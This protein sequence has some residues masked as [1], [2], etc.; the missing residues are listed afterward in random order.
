MAVG[1]DRRVGTKRDRYAKAQRSAKHRA[2]RGSG[3]ARLFGN[4]GWIVVGV[5]LDPIERHEGGDKETAL[6]LHAFQRLFGQEAAVLDRIDAGVDGE[7][8]GGIAVR[9]GCGLAGTI[10]SLSD[11]GVEL[12]ER[13]ERK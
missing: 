11:R 2:M 8:R 9:M 3:D 6:F 4:I 10:M 7:P 5:L 13:A 12:G 1:A